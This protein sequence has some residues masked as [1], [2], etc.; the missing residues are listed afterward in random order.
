M[1]ISNDNQ[2]RTAS[3]ISNHPIKF[4]DTRVGQPRRNINQ[5]N[6]LPFRKARKKDDG[7]SNY[8]SRSDIHNTFAFHPDRNLPINFSHAEMYAN[9]TGGCAAYIGN[10]LMQCVPN[11]DD[12][13]FQSLENDRFMTITLED[14]LVEN[15]SATSDHDLDNP[16]RIKLSTYDHD[17]FHQVRLLPLPP[18]ISRHQNSK[19][20]P[21]DLT[22]YSIC[23]AESEKTDFTDLTPMTPS[24]PYPIR[25]TICSP[26]LNC[27]LD[28]Q[29]NIYEDLTE[30]IISSSNPMI[31]MH[32]HPDL[33]YYDQ[34]DHRR[35]ISNIGGAPHMHEIQLP[36]DQ[37][38]RNQDVLPTPNNDEPIWNKL[39]LSNAYVKYDRC[40]TYQRPKYSFNNPKTS[41]G[42]QNIQSNVDNSVKNVCS[43]SNSANSSNNIILLANNDT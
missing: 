9:N 43:N 13:G 4:R 16:N 28:P 7:T 41:A 26:T 18:A 3:T 36:P 10:V 39:D 33:S 24:M 29:S 14:A 17:P 22:R 31:G 19:T 8:Q 21:N 32:N 34:S 11:T 42:H 40:G 23:S 2:M 20:L 35:Y 27:E 37:P 15:R 30:A 25:E 6:T 1:P 38:I 12:N 5:S